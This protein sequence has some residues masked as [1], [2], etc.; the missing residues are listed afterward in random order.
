MNQW[1]LND[2][3]HRIDR[4]ID[5]TCSSGFSPETSVHILIDCPIYA[6]LSFSSFGYQKLNDEDVPSLDG[7][8]F[9]DVLPSFLLKTG[10]FQ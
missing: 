4:F 2:H 8:R 10:R 9:N 1:N 5:P 3:L 7:M 6:G